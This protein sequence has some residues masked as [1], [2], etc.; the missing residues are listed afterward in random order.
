MLFQGWLLLYPSGTLHQSPCVFFI[1]CTFP[2]LWSSSIW[3]QQGCFQQ[4]PHL[5]DLAGPGC[6]ILPCEGYLDL[7]RRVA[8]APSTCTPLSSPM[9]S[10]SQVGIQ[11]T[12]DEPSFSDGKVHFFLWGQGFTLYRVSTQKGFLPIQ[13]H[14]T[15]HIFCWQIPAP[16]SSVV[17]GSCTTRVSSPMFYSWCQPRFSSCKLLLLVTVTPVR[18]LGLFIV[19]FFVVLNN[20]TYSWRSL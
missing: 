9:V 8:T 5:P 3:N 17:L 1:S 2:W 11:L 6:G 14:D 15:D 13:A 20:S 10:S 4:R 16:S 7:V 12:L 19:F 18:G